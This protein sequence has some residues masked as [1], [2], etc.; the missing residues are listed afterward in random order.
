MLLL[1]RVIRPDRV[2]NAIKNFI[3][4][5]PC[6]GDYYVKSPIISYDKVYESSTNRNP[7]VFILSPG[8]DPFSDVA[9]LVETKGLGQNKFRYC[10]LGQGMGETARQMIERGAI[11]GHWVML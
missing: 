11:Q 1:M 6:A 3:G 8:A 7:I 2:I 10:A 4:A 9:A 5:Q